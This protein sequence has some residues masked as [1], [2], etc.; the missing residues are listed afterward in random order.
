MATEQINNQIQE[1]YEGDQ[2]KLYSGIMNHHKDIK[3]QE[4]K[5]QVRRII[6]VMIYLAIV[7]SVEA[8]LGLWH[9]PSGIMDAIFIC[10]TLLKAF[11]IVSI[12][13]HLGTEFRNFVMVILI[14]LTLLI[15]AIIAFLG[16]GHSWL[17]DNNTR[18]YS[19]KT[20]TSVQIQ[21]NADRV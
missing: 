13:M 12:F 10:M 5:A 2:S 9:H 8:S 15:W 21:Y 11:L 6:R 16:D 17:H 14:P 18:P 3:S 4:S 1:L 20:T 19:E 7:T